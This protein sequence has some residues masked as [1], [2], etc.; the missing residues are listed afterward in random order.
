MEKE[1]PTETSE[2][3]LALGALAMQFATIQR[4]TYLAD[5]TTHETDTDHTVMLGLMGCALAA[6]HEPTLDLGKIAQFALVHDLVEAYAGDTDTFN[7]TSELHRNNKSAREAAALE[8][9]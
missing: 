8:R 1:L 2:A 5:G 4:A 3:L 9:I 7:L 6:T